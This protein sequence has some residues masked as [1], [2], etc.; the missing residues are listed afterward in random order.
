MARTSTIDSKAT[1]RAE[2]SAARLGAVQALYQMDLAGTDLATVADEFRKHRLGREVDGD[3]YREADSD[4]FVSLIEGVVNTQ[5]TIDPAV[6]ETLAVGWPLVRV[7][8]TLRAILRAATYELM[9]RGDVPA[10]VVISEYL[11]VARA[12][13][14]EGAEP[15]IVNGVLDR[16][17]HDL[18]P[19]EFT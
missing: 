15:G 3:H 18:R 12:F 1:T 7:D 10:R 11:D 6:D 19:E 17:A 13:F 2:R 16:L 14:E 9:Q 4:F 5:T 8:A